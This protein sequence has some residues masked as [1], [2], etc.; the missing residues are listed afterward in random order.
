M[1]LLTA[2]LATVVT[3]VAGVAAARAE[4][5]ARV[6]VRAGTI[7][8]YL[9]EPA[10]L[11]ANGGAVVRFGPSVLEADAVRYD[12]QHNRLVASGHVTLFAH[13]ASA[14]AAACAIDV[15]SGDGTLLRLDGA[16]PTTYAFARGDVQRLEAAPPKPGVFDV[17]DTGRLRPFV[18]SRHAVVTTNANVRFTPARVLTETGAALPSPS[19]LYVFAANPSFSQ[20]SMPVASFDQPYGLF[21]GPNSLFAAHFRYDTTS[22]RPTIGFDEHLVDGN[23]AYA[24]ASVLPF[25]SGGRVDLSGYQQIAPTLGQQVIASH[26]AGFDVA[27]YQLQHSERATTS[28]LI[29]VQSGGFASADVRLSTLG[30][31]IPHFL[32]YKLGIDVGADR[33]AGMLPYP[34]DTR[35]TL[36]GHVATPTVNGP[37]G[38][39]MSS[40]LDLSTTLYD[41]PRERGS[42]SLYGSIS[43]KLS[44]AVSLF[45]SVQFLQ[46]FDR[47]RNGESTFYPTTPPTLPDGSLYY[48]YGAFAGL[49]TYRAYTLQATY[50]PNSSLNLVL[51]LAHNHDFPQFD[52]FGNPPF[53]AGFDLRVRAPRGPTVEFGRTYVFG[54]GNQRWAP[55]YTLSVA[56]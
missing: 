10:V 24:V 45:G 40:S 19:Y 15:S 1:R 53:A 16:L 35:T 30:H 41:F 47:Y 44:P 42:S 43:R 8:L 9:I 34:S 56:P 54:W 4:L 14:R 18:R 3:L 31:E 12:L 32:S 28:T 5:P 55:Y 48:G 29:L 50:S 13:G 6:D 20:Q 26:A 7:E 38:T 21:G 52:G 37:F 46:T 27:Q 23:R 25:I 17:A 22:R 36:L 39:S 11:S 51:T 2:T 33:Q 49:A